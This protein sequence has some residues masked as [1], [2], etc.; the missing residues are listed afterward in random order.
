ML[1][2][3]HSKCSR[4]IQTANACALLTALTWHCRR[5]ASICLADGLQFQQRFLSEIRAA[6]ALNLVTRSSGAAQG[7][8]WHLAAAS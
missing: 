8:G 7:C 4:T 6:V 1:R 3:L 2:R 5:G